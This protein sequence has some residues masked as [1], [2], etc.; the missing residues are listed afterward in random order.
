[1]G[2]LAARRGPS[3]GRAI[4]RWEWM[5]IA[6][7]PAL[8]AASSSRPVPGEVAGRAAV[9]TGTVRPA[10]CWRVARDSSMALA[11]GTH[12]GG[13][14]S[15]VAPVWGPGPHPAPG[16]GTAVV[17]MVAP[18]PCSCR[19]VRLA[20]VCPS[21]C[22]GFPACGAGTEDPAL[23]GG[24]GVI[25]CGHPRARGWLCLWPQS[26]GRGAAWGQCWS[27]AGA[28]TRGAGGCGPRRQ[29][30][31]LSRLLAAPALYCTRRCGCRRA[32][33]PGE[34]RPPPCVNDLNR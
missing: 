2:V 6:A 25:C 21:P 20:E 22:L 5:A 10:V 26:P 27:P 4:F 29:V 23:A 3:A 17:V 12:R 28:R 15:R 13:N 33:G 8:G 31:F 14:G 1:M 30:T 18:G 34:P 11:L 7:A 32:A 9:G 16:G 19:A 24:C